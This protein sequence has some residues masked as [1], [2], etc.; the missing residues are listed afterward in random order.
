VSGGVA[1]TRGQRVYGQ[2]G[3]RHAPRGSDP[4]QCDIFR[5][6]GDDEGATALINGFTSAPTAQVPNPTPLQYRISIGP[7]NECTWDWPALDSPA[8]PVALS[9]VQYTDHQIEIQGDLDGVVPGDLVFILPM[10]YRKET[11]LPYKCHD[12]FGNYVPCRL[13]S[14]G[15][16]YYGVP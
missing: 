13:L 8:R 10:E 5:I 1:G 16:F 9:I 7:P 11:D 12:N 6:V 2:H 4:A 15:E 14:T 3:T